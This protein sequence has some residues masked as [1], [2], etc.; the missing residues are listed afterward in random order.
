MT[1]K[2]LNA[3]IKEELKMAGYKTNSFSVLTRS[4]R[5]D[6]V[7]HITIKTPEI[8]INDIRKLLAHWEEIDHD[9]RT[10]EVLQGANTYM[11][12]DYK[13]VI[14]DSIAEKFKAAAEAAFNS[15]QEVF[16]L[17]DDTYLLNVHG[18]KTIR[19]ESTHCCFIVDDT[20]HLCKFMCMLDLCGTIRL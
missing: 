20:D 10:G 8:N 9:T 18:E 13:D 2:E 6:T 17:S 4:S 15:E 12:I 7:T 3:A 1:N 5:Y 16:R 11:R 14:F 19:Q